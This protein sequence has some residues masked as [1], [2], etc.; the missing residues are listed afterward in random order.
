MKGGGS[1]FIAHDFLQIIS[2]TLSLVNALVGP[3][4][5]MG[6]MQ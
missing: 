5:K 6:A 2:L 1:A 4:G 3:D